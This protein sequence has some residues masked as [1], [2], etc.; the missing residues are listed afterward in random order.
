MIAVIIFVTD[1]LHRPEYYDN[2][3]NDGSLL[4]CVRKSSVGNVA[5]LTASF[6][7]MPSVLPANTHTHRGTGTHTCFWKVGNPSFTQNARHW[8]F[9]Q[10][11]TCMESAYCSD[12]CVSRLSE[13]SALVTGWKFQIWTENVFTQHSSIQECSSVSQNTACPLILH[14]RV[15]LSVCLRSSSIFTVKVVLSVL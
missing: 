15:F 3:I 10:R 14:R 12:G 9:S 1:R 8:G 13:F 5:P 6:N 4:M 11:E 7:P 2:D